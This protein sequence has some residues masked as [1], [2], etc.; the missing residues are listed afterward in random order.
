MKHSEFFKTQR[1]FRVAICKEYLGRD[2]CKSSRAT[3]L[4]MLKNVSKELKANTINWKRCK[5]PSKCCVQ[6]WVRLFRHQGSQ[7]R[8]SQIDYIIQPCFVVE[9]ISEFHRAKFAHKHRFCDT[10]PTRSNVIRLV[11]GSNQI[12]THWGGS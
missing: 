1:L 7:Q 5:Y 3:T 6:R 12:C 9:K 2:A 8:N 10:F 4:N 11:F